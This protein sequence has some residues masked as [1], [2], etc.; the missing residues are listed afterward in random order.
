MLERPRAP[1]RGR[2][3]LA[4]PF[5]SDR[6]HRYMCWVRWARHLAGLG[7][8]VLRFD[9]R[10][11]GEST[12]AFEGMSID[13]WLDDIQVCGR[14]LAERGPR[15]P[16]A[17]HG[18]GLGALLSSKLFDEGVG[19]AC[20]LWLPPA[21]GKDMLFEQ[22]KLRLANDFAL[23]GG[24]GRNAYIA[25]LESGGT[26]D[27]E[28]YMWTARLWRDAS[29]LQ[30]SD[31]PLAAA[32]NGKPRRRHVAALD[33]VA[34]HMFGG[35]GRT[36]CEFRGNRACGWSC[37]IS[38]T[39]SLRT[40]PGWKR[41]WRPRTRHEGSARRANPW[42]RTRGGDAYAARPECRRARWARR[43]DAQ[44]RASNRDRGWATSASWWLTRSAAQVIASSAST[45][46]G[47]E[48]PETSRCT[49]KSCGDRFRRAATRPPLAH[50]L[51]S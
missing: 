8:E 31:A 43:A 19:D 40:Q 51:A 23:G 26:V 35:I 32:S 33:P 3:L 13:T 25:T 41:R 39:A 18:L 2:V 46:P 44:F 37:P 30:L 36:R 11:V 47:S 1:A 34:A 7:F 38:V 17:L 5:A 28:G 42:A 14:R 27:V 15:L 21:S 49:W 20:L 9:Y 16:L 45:C 12:G 29:A 22:L 24:K 6:P 4:G 10:G 48:I 50:W